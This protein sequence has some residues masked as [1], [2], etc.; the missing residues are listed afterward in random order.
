MRYEYE[1]K[2]LVVLEIEGKKD[3]TA[4]VGPESVTVRLPTREAAG[5]SLGQVVEIETSV[6]PEKGV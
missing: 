2:D 5:L 6:S 4:A 1:D 3:P